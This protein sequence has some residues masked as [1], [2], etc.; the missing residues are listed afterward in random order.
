M[1]KN[2]PLNAFTTG[3][4]QGMRSLANS[5]VTVQHSTIAAVAFRAFTAKNPIFSARM[6][7]RRIGGVITMESAILVH[8]DVTALKHLTMASSVK[9]TLALVSQKME[10]SF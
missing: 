6:G 4:A 1:V 9:H 5:T 2:A 3:N 10:T 8:S 7:S